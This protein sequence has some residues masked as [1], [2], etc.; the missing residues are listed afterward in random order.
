VALEHP[1]PIDA[2]KNRGGQL[3]DFSVVKIGAAGEHAAKKDGGVYGGN[4]R[5][6]DT[7]AILN[8][9]EVGVKAML[10]LDAGSHETQSV[11]NAIAYFHTLFPA[12]LIGNAMS[13]E[14]KAG[15][16]DAGGIA[17]VGTVGVA[18]IFNQ[19]GGGVGFVPKELEAGALNAFQKFI[20]V[21]SEAVLGGVVLKEWRA[22]RRLLRGRLTLWRGLRAL[23]GRLRTLQEFGN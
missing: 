7:F 19:A 15:G 16:S 13:G 8:V 23:L 17:L 20:F 4:F 14:S 3:V 22:L 6:E 12:A 9:Q 1:K 10:V 18:A 21:T 5:L 2:L 11:A